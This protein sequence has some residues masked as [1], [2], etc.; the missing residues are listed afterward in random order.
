M[1]VIYWIMMLSLL[2]AACGVDE[3][4]SN[5]DDELS[6]G[7]EGSL[8]IVT[9]D[10]SNFPKMGTETIDYLVNFLND[11]DSDIICFQGVEDSIS[12]NL[13]TSQLI[14]WEGIRASNS[15]NNINLAIL[16]KN[17]DNFYINSIDEIFLNDDI[18]FPR[19]PFQIEFNWL[20][21]DFVVINNQLSGL[22]GY[23]NEQYRAEAC[24]ILADYVMTNYNNENV[25]ITGNFNSVIDESNENSIFK[26]FLDD[27]ENFMF[28][29]DGIAV[30]PSE[31]WSWNNGA[32]HLDH[33]IISNELYDENSDAESTTQTLRIDDYMNGGWDEYSEFIADHRPVALRLAYYN[34]NELTLG[35][36][37]TLEIVTWNLQTF[38]KLQDE[39]IDLVAQLI[40]EMDAD[41]ICL[42]EI[43]DNA[44]FIELDNQLTNWD[45]FRGSGAA[46]SINLSILYK[47][48]A[49]FQLVSIE[50]LFT[51]EWYAFPRSPL[52]LEF[53]WNNETFFV[54]NNHLKASGGEDNEARRREASE[55]LH[56]YILTELPDEN[57]IIT[58]DLNDLIID[59]PDINVFDVFLQDPD[60]FLFADYD[61]AYGSALYWSWNN[62]S[63]HLDHIIISNE[64]FD[65]FTNSLSSIQT[66]RIDDYLGGGWSFYDDFISDHRPVAITL[67]F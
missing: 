40:I 55:S 26:V 46:Y 25:V 64:L 58:G 18:H 24:T 29:D 65:E 67:H 12:F 13:L 34:D 39:T 41:I 27:P 11:I 37:E 17:Y 16:Y 51:N 43:E 60:N 53:L 6:F 50:E 54:I 20:G 9:W 15:H 21:E 42:Q 49:D 30:G 52:K 7:R 63:S 4:I 14:N 59:P 62:G 5:N 23:E 32:S 35:S 1:K 45:G 33:I 36:D 19:P 10:I 31:N 48:S 66:I 3:S 56:D 2:L 22:S 61:I 38:P 47:N 28:A 44:A 8:E 57:V